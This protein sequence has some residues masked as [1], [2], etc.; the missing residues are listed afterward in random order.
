MN[1]LLIG[2]LIVVAGAGAFFYLRKKNNS[3]TGNGIK[4]EWI[5]GK[6]KMDSID[7]RKT[8]DS[9]SLFMFA[10]ISTL[11]SNLYRYQ[12]DFRKDNQI[13]SSL[14]DSQKADTIHYEWKKGNQLLWKERGDTTGE[15][16]S[17]I[18]LNKDS[19]VLQSK[20]SVTILFTKLM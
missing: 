18:K 13:I 12:Y 1:K 14:P 17:L 5:V 9:N 4:K 10:L 8:K 3:T 15:I 20:D 7:V 11:D 16:L 2:L 6:W 19:L